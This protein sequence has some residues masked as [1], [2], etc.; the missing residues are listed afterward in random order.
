MR[1]W[2]ATAKSVATEWDPTATYVA[3]S[4]VTYRGQVW[5]AVADVAR[6]QYPQGV[7][8]GSRADRDLLLAQRNGFAQAVTG[9]DAGLTY[10]VTSTADTSTPGTLR[11]GLTR[12][13][14]LW[15]V[16]DKALGPNVTIT[17]TTKLKPTANKTVDGRG[18][19][20][21]ITGSY[22]ISIK[23]LGTA[24]HIW[25]YIDRIVSPVMAGYAAH[26][27]FSVDG[28]PGKGAPI[29]FDQFWVHHVGFGQNAD[30][31]MVLAKAGASPSRS[32][33]DWCRFGPTPGIDAWAY[34]YNARTLGQDNSADNGK[35]VL[36]GLDPQDGASPDA[37]QT[38]FHHNRIHG[39]VQRNVKVQRGRAHFYN[40]YVDRWGYPP[41]VTTPNDAKNH[42]DAQ[43][44]AATY[45][46]GAKKNAINPNYGPAAT[47]AGADAELLCQNNVFLP[48]AP[49]EEHVLS[50]A[51]VAAGYLTSPWFV[52]LPQTI[53]VRRY[54]VKPN[55]AVA[56]PLVKSSGN[57]SPAGAIPG[58]DLAV[59]PEQVFT[60]VTYASATSPYPAIEG[61]QTRA[62]GDDW[63]N[64]APYAYSLTPADAVLQDDLSRGTGNVQG[65]ALETA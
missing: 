22:D 13:E 16:F 6:G 29:G 53:A 59:H 43:S 31:L 36:L 47:E 12:K 34:A 38:T 23:G 44:Y 28:A 46:A 30:D 52:T 25:C 26:H 54:P 32:T 24:N 5:R 9:G 14:P 41:L 60:G 2:A 56:D 50:P 1:A 51:L 20:V 21:T 62:A 35:S 39:A 15:I 4:S 58:L 45:Q 10:V 11:Y 55:P 61:G 8:D 48:Y 49:N 63:R 40:N 64:D 18:V 57:W 3:G 7:G 42:P 17:L 27:D 19:S 37:I 33:V 65:W